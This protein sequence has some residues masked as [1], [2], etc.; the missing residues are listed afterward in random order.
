MSGRS[1]A[2]YSVL[3]VKNSRPAKPAAE[4]P[5][6][7]YKYD[8]ALKRLVKVSEGVPGLRKGGLRDEPAPGPCG[9][10]ACGGGRCAP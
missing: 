8:R 10:S 1:P 6:G 5:T 2:G 3:M 7:T 9:R 4:A